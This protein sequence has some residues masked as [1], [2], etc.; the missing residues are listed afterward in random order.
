MS[1]LQQKLPEWMLRLGLGLVYLYSSYD[2]FYNTQQWKSYVSPWLFHLITPVMPLDIFL[3]V[4]ATGEFILALVLIARFFGARGV[5]IAALL[6]T[7]EMAFILLFVGIDRIT[8]RDIGL[9]GAALA[10][11]FMQRSHYGTGTDNA[12]S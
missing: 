1:S 12:Q 11:F 7:L 5:R 8:F 3:K 6:A 4:Q 10:L 9:L 2:I